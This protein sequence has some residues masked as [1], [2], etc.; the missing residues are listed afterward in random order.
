MS[1]PRRRI[2]EKVEP[3]NRAD[4][5]RVRAR[6]FQTDR[7]MQSSYWLKYLKPLFDDKM[8][9]AL[10]DR[11]WRPETGLSKCEAIAL[12]CARQSGKHDALQDFL[13]T[14]REWISKGQKV[15][16]KISKMERGTEK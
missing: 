4:L 7:M 10:K 14:L 15:G 6:G 3:P 8:Q 1:A 16:E 11:Q 9:T 2:L 13:S 5:Y 12:G